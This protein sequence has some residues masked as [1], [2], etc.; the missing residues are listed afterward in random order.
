MRRR[1]TS[2]LCFLTII[3]RFSGCNRNIMANIIKTN[4]QSIEQIRKIE[5]YIKIVWREFKIPTSQPTSLEFHDWACEHNQ[6]TL[7]SLRIPIGEAISLIMSVEYRGQLRTFYQADEWY[8]KKTSR[9]SKSENGT[10]HSV[11]M[12]I[13]EMRKN[14]NFSGKLTNKIMYNRNVK[15]E[16]IEFQLQNRE[17]ILSIRPSCLHPQSRL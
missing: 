8:N 15:I 2:S 14:S 17:M 11:K 12:E 9:F 4:E 3:N 13:V 6:P 16:P 10:S 5:F 1:T 7:Q